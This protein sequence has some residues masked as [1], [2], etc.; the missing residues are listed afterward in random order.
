MNNSFSKNKFKTF[1]ISHG[2]KL[3]RKVTGHFIAIFPYFFCKTILLYF[4][5]QVN[6]NTSINVVSKM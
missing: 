5:G 3:F 2:A 1:F 4:M 6:L